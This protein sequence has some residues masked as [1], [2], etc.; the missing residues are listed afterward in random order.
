MLSDPISELSETRKFLTTSPDTSVAAAVALMLAGGA[1]A[2]LVVEQGALTG[3]FT[4]HDVVSRVIAEGRDPRAVRVGDVMTREPLTVSPQSTL[5]R[6]LV[7]MHERSIRHLPVVQDGKPVGVVC[8]R[9]ALD[10]ELED[11]ICEE[12]RREQF[13]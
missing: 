4:E 10:P 5:G 13:R 12:R 9:D 7:L 6:A 11:F 1:S 8:A 3:I 2:V